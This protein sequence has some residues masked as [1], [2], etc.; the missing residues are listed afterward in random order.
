MQP[1]VRLVVVARLDDDKLLSKLAPLLALDGVAEVTLVRRSPLS[2]PGIRNLCPP[3]WMSRLAP[4]A[5]LWRLATVLRL[6]AR[7]PRPSF[8]V[9][10]YLVPHGLYAEIA[11]RLFGARTIQVTLS[12]QDVDAARRWKPLLRAL[13]SAHA[14]GVRGENSATRLAAAGVEPGRLFV[15]PNVYDPAAFTPDPVLAPDVDV[16]Y[17]GGLVPCKRVDV[18]LRAAARVARRRPGLRVAVV[19]D[20]DR[21]GDLQALAARLGLDGIVEFVGDQPPPEVARWL[22]RA[23]LFALTSEVEGLPM[24]M[25]EALSCGVPVVVPDVGDVTTVA[26]HDHNAWV[27]SAGTPEAFA[28]AIGALLADEGR[29]RRLAQGALA[30]RERFVRECSLQAARQAWRPVLGLEEAPPAAR[31]RA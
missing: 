1:S 27:V 23:R 13:T 11:R 5:E 4:L 26:R 6:C 9:A 21:R 22:R 25:L 30:T 12:Q 10:F 24:A 15:P 8:V 28:E 20:G 3:R 16:V 18:L 17:V 19:G 7:E 31:A 29:R 14:V 2:A